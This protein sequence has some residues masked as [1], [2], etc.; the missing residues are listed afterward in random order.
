ML[1]PQKKDLPKELHDQLKDYVYDIIGYVHYVCKQL[2]CGMA[3]Y[4]YQEAFAKTLMKNG[5][6]PHKEYIH[7]PIFDGEPLEAYQ[8]MDFMVERQRGNIIIEAKAIEKLTN[9]ER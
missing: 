1:L 5:I 4:L 3:E 8:K 2:P 7:H 6:D 9:K